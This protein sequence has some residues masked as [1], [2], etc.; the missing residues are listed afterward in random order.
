[1]GKLK[2]AVGVFAFRDYKSSFFLL[3]QRRRQR[4]RQ[5]TQEW[6]ESCISDTFV[7]LRNG[8]KVGETHNIYSEFEKNIFVNHATNRIV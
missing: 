7:P 6:M 1:M 3:V 2:L 4:N 5:T 8:R